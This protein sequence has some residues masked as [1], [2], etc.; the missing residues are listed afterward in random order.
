V[1]VQLRTFV[2]YSQLP[3]HGQ[4]SSALVAT[5]ATGANVHFMILF[6]TVRGRV[7]DSPN[8]T[9]ARVRQILS[10]RGLTDLFLEPRPEAPPRVECIGHNRKIYRFDH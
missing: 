8:Q 10:S 3:L 1:D 2:N 9:A 6:L 5:A 7:L 4:K